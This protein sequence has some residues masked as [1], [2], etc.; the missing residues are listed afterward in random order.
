MNMEFKTKIRSLR[1]NRFPRISVNPLCEYIEASASRRTSIIRQSKTLPTF[2][3]RWYNQAEDILAFYLSEIRDDSRVLSI[4]IERLKSLS[5][6]KDENERKYGLA[7]AESLSSF[8]TYHS[9]IQELFSKYDVT[10]AVYDSKH[11][12]SINGVQISIRPELLLRSRVDGKEIGF[13]KF[14]FSKM[15]SLSKDRGEL[16]ACLGKEYFSRIYSLSFKNSD[17]IILDVYRGKV[18]TAPRASVKRIADIEA[19]CQEISDRW[20][21]VSN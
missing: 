18:F 7:S 9:N 19:S 4:E 2:I 13:V 11:K 10:M 14:Y 21:R 17:C 15:E 5:Y 8:L 3:T 20:D 12:L 1:V 16:M 6:T